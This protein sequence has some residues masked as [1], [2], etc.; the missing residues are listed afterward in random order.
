MRRPAFSPLPEIPDH[1]AIEHGVLDWWDSEQVFERLRRQ[2]SGGPR[3]SFIDGPITANNPAG[4]HHCWGRGLKD[5]FQRYKALRG[6]D[7][8]YQNGFDCQGLWVEV[9]VERSLGLNSKHEIEEYGI[10]RF[11]ERCKERVAKYAGVITEQS[12]RLGMWMDWSNSYFTFSD[13]NIAYIWAFL[14][15][16][17]QRGWLYKGHRSTPW[18]PR[19]GTSLSQHEQIDSYTTMT[20]PS[21]Y[22]R[23]PLLDRPDEALVIW[24][25]TPWTLPANVA[26]AVHPDEDYVLLDSG[27]Y[28]AMRRLE[29]LPFAGD[30]VRTVKGSDLVGLRYVGPFDDLPAQKDVVHRVI[31]W[32]SVSLSEGTGIVHIAPG[33]GAEDFELSREHGLA[34]LV[35]IDESG[36]FTAGYGRFEGMDTE[37]AAAPILESLRSRSLLVHH[38]EITHRYPVCWRCATPLVFR[39]VDDWF[40]SAEEI[41]PQMLA[42]NSTVEW[43]PPFYS[44][45]MDDWL[46]NMDDWNISRKRYFG[47]PLPIY[48][49]Q[50][51]GTVTV[52]GSRAELRERATVGLDQLKELHRPWI[53]KV[54]IRCEQCGGEVRRIPDVGDAWLDAGIVPFSTLGWRNPEWYPGGYATGASNVLSGA[55]LPDHGYWEQWFPADWISE[56]REQIRLWFYSQSFMSVTLEGRSPYRKVLTYEKVRDETGR[57]MHKSWGNAIEADVA[58]ER[59]GADVMRWIFAQ[60]T[61]GQDLNF[62]FARGDSVKRELLTLWNSVRFL[63]TYGNIEGFQPRFADLLE[64][65]AAAGS[66]HVL[67]RWLLARVQELV[68]KVEEGFEK[69]WTPAVVAAFEEFVDDLSNWYIR[70]SR[71]RFYSYD[72]PAFRTLWYAIVRSLMAVAPVMPFVTEHLWKAL[73]SEACADPTPDSVFLAGWMGVDPRLRDDR[74]LAEVEEARHVVELGRQARAAAN[75][76]LRQPLRTLLV[77]GAEQAAAQVDEIKEELRVK[78]VRFTDIDAIQVDAQ[79]NYRALGP[80]YGAAVSGIASALRE[81]RYERVN[82]RIRVGDRELEAE[83][84]IVSYR[85]PAGWVLVQDGHTIA[86]LD[87][88]VDEELQMEGRV[89]ELIHR[90][91]TMRKNAGLE[92][93]DRIALT[94]P[95]LDRDLLASEQWIK[96]EVLAVSVEAAGDDLRLDSLRR[97]SSAPT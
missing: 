40:I 85:A 72:E 60:Q 16:V 62:G 92:L 20:H 52:I 58:L 53:D 17:H 84:V 14:K 28:V 56:M 19:C 94:I 39:V 96:Q 69:S 12:K 5:M 65:P 54:V 32:T 1:S 97:A 29:E 37:Q 8:R 45:R 34:V 51:C 75:V 2:N 33:C 61:P 6:F 82:G 81:G 83:D 46:R 76:R 13:T 26:G 10:A 38:G 49:C 4:V 41:R 70:R 48:P 23:F 93:T 74:L 15:E 43:V 59:M 47:L 91:N 50:S 90:V 36:H 7:Q 9:E 18:C 67:D 73:V 24:T 66:G 31:P 64:G 87:T 71:R 79:P 30:P 3:W 57:E 86:M 35:P 55:D 89:L 22:V 11:A 21:L 77:Q 80:K 88:R 44:K 95:A 78:E 68:G 27:D 63:T 42:A 25:T